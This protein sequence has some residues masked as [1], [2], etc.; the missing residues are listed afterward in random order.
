M[1]LTFLMELKM[2][3]IINVNRTLILIIP[4]TTTIIIIIITIIIFKLI[5]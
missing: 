4:T 2:N 3:I 1:I 5:I